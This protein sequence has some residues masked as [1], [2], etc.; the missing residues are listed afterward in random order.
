M[1]FASANSVLDPNIPHLNRQ[2]E[3][4]RLHPEDNGVIE[5]GKAGNDAISSDLWERGLQLLKMH[6]KFWKRKVQLGAVPWWGGGGAGVCGSLASGGQRKPK[7]CG[8]L[9]MDHEEEKEGK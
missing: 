1:P 6:L 5:Y 2:V 9:G 4:P 8:Y 7:P 3:Q